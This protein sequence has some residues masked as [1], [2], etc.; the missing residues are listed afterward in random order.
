MFWNFTLDAVGFAAVPA[1]ASTRLTTLLRGPEAILIVWGAGTFAALLA[2]T[3]VLRPVRDSIVLD[4]DPAFIPWLFLATFG[5]ML[6]LAPAWGKLVA[7]THRRR[8]V[9]IAYHLA[10]GSS[11]VFAVLVGWGRWPAVVGQ[12]FYV[13]H[14]VINLFVVSV[15]WSVCADSL[16][17]RRAKRLYGAI[18]VGGT[19]GAVLG[20]ILA[21]VLVPVIHTHGLFVAAAILIELAIFGI[22]QLDRAARRLRDRLGDDTDADAVAEAPVPG[23]AFDGLRDVGRSPFLV[24]ISIYVLCTAAGATFVYLEQAD[25][26]KEAFGRDRDL[27]TAFFATIDTYTNIGA[28]LL[29]AVVAAPLL[30]SAGAGA[31]LAILPVVQG[32]AIV[33]LV[34]S[35]SL[36]TL[37]VVQVA[38]RATTHGLIRPAREVLFT[39]VTREQKYRAKNVIDTLI[40]RFGDVGS[41]WMHKGLVLAGLGSTALLV[42]ALPVAAVWLG[43][44]IVLGVWF[45]RRAKD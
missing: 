31:V 6:V 2:G 28:F 44:A 11:L 37:R 36:E 29:Q 18:S 20:P 15:M 26:I 38:A 34:V 30:A 35:P 17:P 13:W 8:F 22:W 1:P 42:V 32:I 4:G 40:Y 24:A 19:A 3:F 21:R 43:T 14:A 5:V 10:A 9:A 45:R 12:A 27:R 7:T 23:G 39:V 33:S 41:A 25:I 16:G